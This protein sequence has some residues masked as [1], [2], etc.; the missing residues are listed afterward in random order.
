MIRRKYSTLWA[1]TVAVADT[2]PEYTE[3]ILTDVDPSEFEDLRDELQ[4]FLQ[5]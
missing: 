5:V 2:V 1:C 4:G 3:A